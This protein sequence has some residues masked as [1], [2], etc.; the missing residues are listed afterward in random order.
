M[1]PKH[2]DRLRAIREQAAGLRRRPV[3]DAV[4][5]TNEAADTAAL[6]AHF[7]IAVLEQVTA[8]RTVQR[9]PVRQI[10]PALD[11]DTRQPRLLPLLEDVVMNGEPVPTDQ[12][13]IDELRDLGQSLK[14]RQ[15]QPIIVYPGHSDQYPEARYLILVGH[16]RWLAAQLSTIPELD[17]IVIDPPSA[18]ERIQLQYAENEDRA[19]FTDMERAW[20]LQ[21]M[22]QAL[23]D[24]PWEAV[25]QRFRLSTSRRH[26]LTRLLAFT[27]S[28]QQMI[29]QLRLRENQLEPLHR[30]VRSGELTPSLVDTVLETIWRKLQISNSPSNQSTEVDSGTITRLVV[31]AKRADGRTPARPP[32]WYPLFRTRVAAL[33]KDIK[34]LEPRF[35]ELGADEQHQLIKDIESLLTTSHRAFEALQSDDMDG[36]L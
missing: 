5:E 35:A 32:Q 11:P 8:G 30:A 15:I 28:Q 33:I 24:A 36:S 20:A 3:Q 21:Q 14:Q 23:D 10:A 18:S 7:G 26:E 16:R 9:L 22:K 25:E 1:P 19:D 27:P 6:S 2:D 12:A 31:Q 4:P 17:A 29:A 13:L 34:R